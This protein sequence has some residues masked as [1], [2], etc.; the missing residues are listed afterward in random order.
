M[1]YPMNSMARGIYM[2]NSFLLR[3]EGISKEFS[4]VKVLQDIDFNL[5]LVRFMHLLVKMV[6]ASPH[7]LRLFQVYILHPVGEFL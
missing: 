4:K 7:L 5:N 3:T 2:R 6:Q 1:I